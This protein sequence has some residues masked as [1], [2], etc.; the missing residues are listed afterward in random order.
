MRGSNLSAPA[1]TVFSMKRRVVIT[2]L[3]VVTSLSCKVAELWKRLC[4][5]ESGIH[6]LRTINTEKLKIK[7]GGDVWDWEPEQ[8]PGA[9][10]DRKE[11]KR[12][13]RFTQFALVAGFDAV[14]DSGIDFSKENPHRCGVILGSGIGG[15]HEIVKQVVR[16]V[17]KGP[18]RVSP[19]LV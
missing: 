6:L 18:D 13:D 15:L 8:W 1:F 16:M 10:Q 12:V 11:T 19:F 14:H 3:G 9:F 7:I 2:G 4:A 5:G 17:E